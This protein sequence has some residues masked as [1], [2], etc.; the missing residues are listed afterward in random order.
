VS[1][2]RRG[3]SDRSGRN[4][5][6][7]GASELDVRVL[8]GRPEIVVDLSPLDEH[9]AGRVALVTGAAGSLGAELSRR[10]AERKPASLVLVDRAESALYA[11]EQEL[12]ESNPGVEVVP[13]LADILDHDAMRRAH[14]RSSPAF[15]FHAA[16]YK[17]VPMVERHPAE[18]VRN[19]VGGTLSV[20][21]AALAAGVDRFVFISTDKAIRP[22]SVMGASKRTGELLLQALASPP[23]RP[24]RFITVRFGNVLDSRGNVVEQF[25]RQIARGGPVMI[26]HPAMRR[27]FMTASE[28]VGLVLRAS[29]L[30]A[31]GAVFLL[32]IDR[33]RRIIDLARQM[34]RQAALEPGRSI[35]IR[36]DKPR[37]GEKLREDYRVPGLD[38]RPTTCP[39][40]LE[41]APPA[42]DPPRTR[43]MIQTLLDLATRGADREVVRQLSRIV[44][45]YRPGRGSR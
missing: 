39:H 12:R 4:G 6:A 10:I 34:I 18:G 23:S 2:A 28:A 31:S 38:L 40:V 45:D 15:V 32:D 21:R 44:P 29:L 7:F 1:P 41:A 8:L 30:G 43:R 19:N 22:S 20:A 5:F 13:V 24:T 37:P 11:L 27:Y 36:V 35:A 17:H 16:A 26:T 42:V 33:P 25:Q 14:D 3:G 9:L